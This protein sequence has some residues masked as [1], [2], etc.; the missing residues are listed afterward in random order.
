MWFVFKYELQIVA[1]VRDLTE[2]DG[3]WRSATLQGDCH[4]SP[5][6]FEKYVITHL[7]INEET[8]EILRRKSDSISESTILHR[9]GA[10]S[11]EK[12]RNLCDCGGMTVR[13]MTLMLSSGATIV[14]GTTTPIPKSNLDGSESFHERQT[15]FSFRERAREGSRKETKR[16]GAYGKHNNQPKFVSG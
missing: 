16:I 11:G 1:I 14:R 13:V 6:S 4:R 10:F 5:G 15:W 3:G 7:T 12:V 9:G 2:W 8:K